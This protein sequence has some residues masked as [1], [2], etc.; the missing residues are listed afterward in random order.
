MGEYRVDEMKVASPEIFV[1]FPSPKLA[2]LLIQLVCDNK[3]G[4][5]YTAA[6][7]KLS[8][9]DWKC[10]KDVPVDMAFANDNIWLM[11]IANGFEIPDEVRIG[12]VI[13]IIEDIN[14]FPNDAL[15]HLIDQ[16]ISTSISNEPRRMFKQMLE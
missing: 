13:I 8:I 11:L 7:W 4:R 15:S 10:R 16:R 5:A 3:V 9:I 2:V 14:I 1:Y 6:N 12:E